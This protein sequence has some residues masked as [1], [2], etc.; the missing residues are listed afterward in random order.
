MNVYDLFSNKHN[1]V[2]AIQITELHVE[3]MLSSRDT[4]RSGEHTS[5]SSYFEAK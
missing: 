1:G 4:T 5:F 3:L 2:A